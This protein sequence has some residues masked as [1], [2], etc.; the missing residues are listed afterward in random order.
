MDRFKHIKSFA[1][2]FEGE[3]DPGTRK[4]YKQAKV[5]IEWSGNFDVPS[6]Q[7]RME[8]VDSIAIHLPMHRAEDFENWCS[9][10]YFENYELRKQHEVLQK[11]Y[12][13]YL[14]LAELMRAQHD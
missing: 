11:A 3:V 5:P 12:D 1:A 10:Q 6:Y 4:F 14:M 7:I 9:D 8:T 13:K 2:T